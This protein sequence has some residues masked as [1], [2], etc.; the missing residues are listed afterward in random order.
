MIRISAEPG[1]SGA[2]RSRCEF[3][4]WPW[5]ADE[6]DDLWQQLRGT[7]RLSLIRD[8]TYL[9]WR[10]ANH[11]AFKYSLFGVYDH[12]SPIGWLVSTQRDLS[13]SHNEEVRIQDMLLP[14]DLM[15][16][17]L[18]QAASFLKAQSLILWLPDHL[19]LPGMES[20]VTGWH[21][22]YRALSRSL[23]NQFLAANVFYSLGEADQWWW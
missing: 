14:P 17:V 9:A 4:P 8:R 23:T 15:L 21:A 10:Y 13:S 2:D 18:Q 11:P 22:T 12:H 5:E 16:P 6:I 20:R 19:V 3:R 7:I 1:H